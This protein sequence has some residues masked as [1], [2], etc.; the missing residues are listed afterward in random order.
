MPKIGQLQMNLITEDLQSD[1]V[2]VNVLV[3]LGLVI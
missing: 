3:I 1:I 2:L